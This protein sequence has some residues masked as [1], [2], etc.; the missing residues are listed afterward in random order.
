MTEFHWHDSQM[1][2]ELVDPEH[3]TYIPLSGN[4]CWALIPTNLDWYCYSVDMPNW[5][6]VLKRIGF[7][8]QIAGRRGAI[9]DVLDD[10]QTFYGANILRL[11]GRA[12]GVRLDVRVFPDLEQSM[13]YFVPSVVNETGASRDIKLMVAADFEFN[14]A[15]WGWRRGWSP[16]RRHRSGAASRDRVHA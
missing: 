14:P 10:L 16:P 5:L 4:R 11:T 3:P 15:P 13:L 8:L 9:T 6:R 7:Y 1:E 12:D 2:L